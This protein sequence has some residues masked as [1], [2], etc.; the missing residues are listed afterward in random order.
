MAMTSK[1][2]LIADKELC[3][4]W[5][6]IVGDVRFDRMVMILKSSTFD[7]TPTPEQADGINKFI[8]SM[9]TIANPDA[10]PIDFP[11]PGLQHNLES[12]RKTIGQTEKKDKK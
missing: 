12:K 2:L 11:Q 9:T 1:E 4:W 3:A 8:A 6:G 10:A 7:G 5:N